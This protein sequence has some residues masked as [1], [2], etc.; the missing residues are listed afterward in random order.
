MRTGDVVHHR[1]TD[2]MWVVA[3]CEDGRVVPMGWP[4]CYAQ[5][6]DCDLTESATDEEHAHFLDALAA[7]NDQSDARCR[8][9]RRVLTLTA[10]TAQGVPEVGFGN[11]TDAA[12]GEA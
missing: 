11:V 1:P 3:F 5:E 4:M 12:Q 2:E 9:A 10:P 7:M 8:Y 6:S